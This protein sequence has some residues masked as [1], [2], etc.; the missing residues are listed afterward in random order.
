MLLQWTYS[1]IWTSLVHN[2][3]SLLKMVALR[4]NAKQH[5]EPQNSIEL[6]QTQYMSSRSSEPFKLPKTRTEKMRKEF[7]FRPSRLA[8][9]INHLIDFSSSTGLKKRII[10][11]L[12]K[13]AETKFNENN[14][15][16]W[17]LACDCQNCREQS[18]QFSKLN[19]WDKC[20]SALL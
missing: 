12:W 13:F 17:Q 7:V 5:H 10:Q 4:R 19:A 14:T 11:L 9:K 6:L 8:N 20:P 16:I 15:C 2:H 1:V 3:S 18:G